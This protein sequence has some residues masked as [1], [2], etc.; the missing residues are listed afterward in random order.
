LHGPAHLGLVIVGI[1]N[2]WDYQGCRCRCGSRSLHDNL[3]LLNDGRLLLL[4]EMWLKS[5]LGWYEDFL[6]QDLGNLLG[7]LLL[8]GPY[9]KHLRGSSP[10]NLI[11]NSLDLV[12]DHL[13]PDPAVLLRLLEGILLRGSHVLHFFEEDVGHG[14][15][16]HGLSDGSTH[17]C[18]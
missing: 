8:T 1:Q 5:R 18:R 14:I 3:W 15:N 4:Y 7:W 12:Q 17:F 10:G 11:Q 2:D 9:L 6:L 13:L 16:H